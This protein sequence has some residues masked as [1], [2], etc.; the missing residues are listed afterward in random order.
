[1]KTYELQILDFKKVRMLGKKVLVKMGSNAKKHWQEYLN[2]GSN[3]LLQE[4]EN[5]VSPKGDCIGFMGGYNP[6]TKTFI[7][8]PGVFVKPDTIVPDGFDYIDI[9]DCNMAVL[10]ITAENPNLEKGAHNLLLKHLKETNY[11]ADYSLGFSAEYYTSVGY[12]NLDKNNPI[13]KFGYFLP[14]KEKLV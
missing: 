7:E 14:C 9:P 4:N 12:V 11:E 1:M 13:Y 3:Q 8:M 10:W 5:R 6:Q 2:D